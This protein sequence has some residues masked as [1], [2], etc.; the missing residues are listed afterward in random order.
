M[1]PQVLLQNPG[2]E[3]HPRFRNENRFM[4]EWV[5]GARPNYQPG[6]QVRAIYY[7]RMPGNRGKQE[8]DGKK[9]GKMCPQVKSSFGLLRVEG[10][11]RSFGAYIWLKSC[12]IKAEESSFFLPPNRSLAKGQGPWVVWV[13]SLSRLLSQDSGCWLGL[14]RRPQVGALSKGIWVGH[15][16]VS[17]GGPIW[18]LVSWLL[19]TSGAHTTQL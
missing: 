2:R 11:E 6:L 18:V 16:V 3:L 14:Q 7:C 10:W 13:V 9:L 17:N 19:L 12:P 1:L 15:V 5:L 8:R 4:R